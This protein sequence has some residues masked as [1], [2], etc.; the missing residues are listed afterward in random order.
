MLEQV[1]CFCA[2][3][4]QCVVRCCLGFWACY[5]E[6]LFR[7]IIYPWWEKLS[8]AV[9]LPQ[10]ANRTNSWWL[11]TCLNLLENAFNKY[12]TKS[13]TLEL[14]NPLKWMPLIKTKGRCCSALLPISAKNKLCSSDANTHLYDAYLKCHVLQV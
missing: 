10:K 7:S 9:I 11:Q 1:C 5:Y 4:S 8:L 3:V 13:S 12:I 6:H 2:C 14:Q